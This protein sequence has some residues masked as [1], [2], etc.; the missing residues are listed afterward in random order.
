MSTPTDRTH[1]GAPAGDVHDWFR[2]GCKLLDEGHPAAAL[3]LLVRVREEAGSSQHLTETMGR[4][5]M[6]VG[7]YA[8]A[9]RD[10]TDLV[11]RHPDDDYAHLGLGLALVRQGRIEQAVEHLALAVAMRP[12]REEYAKYLHQAR[13]TLRARTASR[14]PLP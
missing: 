5:K 7:R 2:R 4:A 10:F 8:D 13:A 1:G 6:A 11:A 12:D 14:E 3:E 9:E